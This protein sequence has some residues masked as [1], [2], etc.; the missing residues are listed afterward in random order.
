MPRKFSPSWPKTKNLV[1]VELI[2][3]S[4]RNKALNQLLFLDFK[5]SWGGGIGWRGV[6]LKTSFVNI[7]RMTQAKNFK[8][9]YVT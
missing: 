9:T 5:Q 1:L 6:K 7:L 8:S 3:P 2:Q 4:T